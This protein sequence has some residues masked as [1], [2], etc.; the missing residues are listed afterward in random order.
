MEQKLLGIKID[1]VQL[2]QAVEIV[3]KWMQ[4]R[5]KHYIST[6]NPEMLVDAGFD[7]DFETALNGSD[8]TIPDSIRLGWGSY[9]KSKSSILRLI[10][11]PF[12][13]F[14]HLLPRFSFPV[15][16]GID[17]MESLLSLSEEKAYTTAF[18][19]G[20]PTV[21]DKLAKCLRQK[22]PNLKIAFCSGNVHVNEEGNMQFDTLNNEMT[23]SK[24]IKD[25]SVILSG[26]EGSVEMRTDSS[27]TVG[28]TGF[29]GKGFNPHTLTQKIDIMFVAFG[30]KKQ[31]KWM[32]KNLPKLNTRIMMGVGGSFDYLS[33]SV[34]RAPRILC[35]VGLE[36]LFRLTVQPWR[37]KRFWKLPVF[38][39]KV[40]TGKQ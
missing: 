39:Y 34:P 2:Y 27:T 16:A 40:M 33:G 17:L 9:I 1:Y 23:R 35:Q 37:I 11:M 28:M 13:L 3:Q 38:I 12:F 5:G 21:A 4:S 10:Y 7:K 19:G 29:R 14:P 6:P 31:E 32:Y 26:A 22:Y 15:I 20:S 25:E 36:W 30:H 18:L 8:L 24:Q